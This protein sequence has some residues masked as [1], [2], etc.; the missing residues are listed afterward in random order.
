M[1]VEVTRLKTQ[2][3]LFY[4]LPIIYLFIEGKLYHIVFRKLATGNIDYRDRW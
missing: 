4:E 2:I 3:A 1:I